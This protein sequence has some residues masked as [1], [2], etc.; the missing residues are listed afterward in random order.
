MA[1]FTFDF[2]DTLV[3]TRPDDEWGLVEAGVHEGNLATLRQL[4]AEGHEVHIVTSRH[5]R[6][7]RSAHHPPR[8]V[9]HEFLAEHELQVAGVHFTSG[10]LKWQTLMQLGSTHHWDDDED[11][12]FAASKVGI[13]TT[14]VACP[15]WD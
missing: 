7:E 11:E 12:I 2:D 1:V 9:I 15:L 6:W 5:A 3:M 14:L 13:G 10:N 8:T 4:L